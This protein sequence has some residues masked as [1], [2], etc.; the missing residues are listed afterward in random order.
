M[1]CDADCTSCEHKGALASRQR[2][3][4]DLSLRLNRVEGQVKGVK[5]MVERGVYC[6]DILIQISAIQSAMNA[7]SK[8][9]LETHMK[10]CVVDRLKAGDDSVTEEFIKTIGRLL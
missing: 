3:V 8:I 10:A 4:K 5:S 9:L 2:V 1:R 6:D 7:V